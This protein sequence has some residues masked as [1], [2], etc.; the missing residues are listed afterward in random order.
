M[1][2]INLEKNVRIRT[3]RPPPGFDPLTAS[4]QDLAQAGFPDR[5][6]DPVLLARYRRFFNRTKG[7]FQYIEPTF[8]VDP[9]KSTHPNKGSR[10]GAGTETYDNWSGG[11]V[12]APSGQSFKWVQGDWVVPNVYPTAQN[13]WQYC[14]NWI[15]L[16]GDGSGDVCQ[17]GMICSVFQSGNSVTRNIF[18][19]HEWY[20]SSWVEITNLTVSP[21]DMISMLICT[22]QGAGSTTAMIFFGN[23]TS[24]ISMSYQI[25][26]PSGTKLVG[27]SAEWIVETPYVNG[28]LTDMPD[29]GEV[30]F[31]TCQAFLNDGSWL[32][33][34]TGN[35]INLVQNGTTLST[36]ALI[37]PTIIECQYAG[38]SA[39]A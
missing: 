28:A 7:R 11:V 17:A 3:F 39:I 25:T 12:Y 26:A 31:S 18:P 6:T 23:H 36:G 32:D 13:Q 33:G 27:N 21:G 15:G 8:R 34:G 22:A 4:A 1:A 24:G 16:D 10:M 35:N 19:W 9:S 38:P 14:A 29:Y 5:P 2:I 37:T 30:F 20:P